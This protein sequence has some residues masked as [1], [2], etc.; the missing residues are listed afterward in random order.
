MSKEFTRRQFIRQSIG[1]GFGLLGIAFQACQ[2]TEKSDQK[3]RTASQ[4]TSCDDL[5]GLSEEEL[6]PRET[7]GYAKESPIT[8]SRCSNCKLWLPDKKKENCG[9][10]LLFKGPVFAAGYC[11]YWAPQI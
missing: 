5:S 3:E 10:C 9:K 6:K 7:F 11:T 1:S 8:D 2:N 4:P